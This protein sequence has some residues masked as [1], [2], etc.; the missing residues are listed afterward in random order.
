[1]NMIWHQAVCNNFNASTHT[2]IPKI[3]QVEQIVEIIE[4][5][6][7]P[8]IASLG[9]MVGNI[10]NYDSWKSSHKNQINIRT[11][12]RGLTFATNLNRKWSG[13]PYLNFRA[14]L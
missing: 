13:G 5:C 9:H 14:F 6:L 12:F 8:T 10:W 11:E 2:K 4:E 7:L 1:M 3:S